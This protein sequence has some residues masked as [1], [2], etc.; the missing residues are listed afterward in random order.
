M[1]FRELDEAV[2]WIDRLL[3][4]CG[5]ESVCGRELRAL[6]RELIDWKKRGEPVPRGTMTRIVTKVCK[7]LCEELLARPSERK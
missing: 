5:V 7:A 4:S 2:L 1:K 6:R 3:Q